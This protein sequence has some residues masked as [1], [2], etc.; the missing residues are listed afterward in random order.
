[1]RK[2]YGLRWY[3][4]QAVRCRGCVGLTSFEGQLDGAGVALVALHQQ[5]RELCQ[6]AIV[7]ETRHRRTRNR[8]RRSGRGKEGRKVGRLRWWDKRRKE[9]RSSDEEGGDVTD[10]SCASLTDANVASK[11]SAGGEARS[12]TASA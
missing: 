1:V 3:L 8:S 5:P 12:T 10:D 9:R 6:E 2:S 4:S 11:S 7:G